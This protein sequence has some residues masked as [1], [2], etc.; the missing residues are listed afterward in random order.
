MGVQVRVGNWE[1]V[2]VQSRKSVDVAS[3][4]KARPLFWLE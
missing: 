1:T 3:F 2:T 4:I